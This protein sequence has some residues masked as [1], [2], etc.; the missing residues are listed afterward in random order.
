MEGVIV[1]RAAFGWLVVGVVARWGRWRGRRRWSGSSGCRDAGVART[2][3][4]RRT[5]GMYISYRSSTIKGVSV[6]CLASAAVG[7]RCD[8]LLR[9]IRG[10]SIGNTLVAQG[11]SP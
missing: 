2:T 5:F 9:W 11:R 6:N 8:R 7:A 10:A 4:A 1:V 3:A